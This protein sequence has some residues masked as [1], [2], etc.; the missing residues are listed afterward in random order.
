MIIEVRLFSY[1]CS[2][3]QKDAN[4]YSMKMEV[5]EGEMCGGL[6]TALSISQDLPV[7]VLVNG[8][9]QDKDYHLREGDQVSFLPPL[10]GG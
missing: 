3:I 10:E 2:K 6:L 7:V 4:R 8:R 5:A 1:L 9:V